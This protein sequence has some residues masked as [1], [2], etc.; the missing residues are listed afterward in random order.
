M[1]WRGDAMGL[2]LHYA[3]NLLSSPPCTSL[4][5]HEQKDRTKTLVEFPDHVSIDYG[6]G[7]YYTVEFFFIDEV[8]NKRK[9]NE[10]CSILLYGPNK[11]SQ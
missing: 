7:R 5:K 3:K 4:H 2:L 8:P 9:K 1:I 10:T 6:T 11:F